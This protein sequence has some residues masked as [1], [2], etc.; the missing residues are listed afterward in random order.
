MTLDQ[1]TGK[2]QDD[3]LDVIQT[4]KILKEQIISQAETISTQ[5][6]TIDEQAKQLTSLGSTD[7]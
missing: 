1:I 5:Q 2:A 3:L 4:I 6:T 7:E